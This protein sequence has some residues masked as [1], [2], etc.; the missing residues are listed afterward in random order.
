MADI[1]ECYKYVT[2][3]VVLSELGEIS[4]EKWQRE[5]D[6]TTKRKITKKFHLIVADRLNMKI[7]IT[8]NFTSMVTE[9]GNIRSY[10]H[11]FK[12]REAPTCP[13]GIEDQT[14]HHLLYECE[15]LNKERYSLILT[16]LKT[17]IWPIIKTLIKKHL[18]L[19]VKFIN[20]ITFDKFNKV[21]NPPYQAD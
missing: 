20:K 16:V 17:D 19:F 14:I 13:C 12:I 4:V 8:H 15:L 7:N 21:S 10:F 2:K 11:P 6:Q 18:K 1:V 3:C 9:H 5:W